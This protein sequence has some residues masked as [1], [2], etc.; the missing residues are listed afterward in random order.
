MFNL[1]TELIQHIFEFC[2]DKRLSWDKLIEQFMKGG[3]NR[4]NLKLDRYLHRQQWCA[5]K[6]WR[7]AR[8][9]ISGE[10][11]LWNSV[12]RRHELCSFSNLVNWNIKDK[13]AVVTFKTSGR[14]I[15]KWSGKDPVSKWLK[16]ISKF[17]TSHPEYAKETYLPQ[18]QSPIKVKCLSKFYVDRRSDNKRKRERQDEKEAAS[19]FMEERKQLKLDKCSFDKNQEVLLSFTMPSGKLKFYRGWVRRIYLHQ[20]RGGNGYRLIF[21]APRGK[22]RFDALKID[23]YIGELKITINFED[24]ESRQYTNRKLIERVQTSAKEL[25]AKEQEEQILQNAN[26]RLL[27]ITKQIAALEKES[28]EIK[29]IVLKEK[30]IVEGWFPDENFECGEEDGPNLKKI[31]IHGNKYFMMPPEDA[32]D[33]RVIIL[34]TKGVLVGVYN[35]ITNKITTA[36]WED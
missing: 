3:Y 22:N 31:M 11:T 28:N 5:R 34:D 2:I 33:K 23:N 30:G 24:G 4:K 9:E 19:L 36:E 25:I 7:S 26:Q 17:E 6:V 1:P 35:D 15:N 21:G 27:V 13:H 29:K 10:M 16:N 32:L 20:H 18:M 12:T 8:P 14:S